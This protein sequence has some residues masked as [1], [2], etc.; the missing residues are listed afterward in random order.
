M[1]NLIN[2]AIKYVGRAFAVIPLY[3]SLFLF[4]VLCVILGPYYIIKFYSKH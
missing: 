1:I 4:A 3:I 2:N